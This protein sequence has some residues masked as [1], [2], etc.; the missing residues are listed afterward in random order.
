MMTPWPG[1]RLGYRNVDDDALTRPDEGS[2]AVV[3]GVLGHLDPTLPTNDPYQLVLE[4]R[5][6]A[7]RVSRGCRGW[8]GP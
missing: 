6:E 2:T 4:A 8:A 5:D 1:W 3:D 7:G